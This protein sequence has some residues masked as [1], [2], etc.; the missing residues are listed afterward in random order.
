MAGGGDPDRVA[1]AQLVAAEVHQ[2]LATR[3][4]CWT[5]TGPSQGSPKH[6]DR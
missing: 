2:R 5:G 4:T 6:I 3:T 1:Q